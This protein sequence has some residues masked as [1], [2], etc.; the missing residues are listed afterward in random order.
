MVAS[1]ANVGGA[2]TAAALAIAKG[3]E[4]LVVPGIL[5]GTLGNVIGNIVGI[6]IGTMFGA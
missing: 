6:V 5:V 1:N 4:S 2:S 3:W